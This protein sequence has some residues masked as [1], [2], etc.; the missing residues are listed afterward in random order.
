MKILLGTTKLNTILFFFSLS[1]YVCFCQNANLTT[2]SSTAFVGSNFTLTC[3][4]LSDVH[5]IGW[6]RNESS[7]GNIT[8][9]C[10]FVD[11]PVNKTLYSFSC[12]YPGTTV[13][14]IKNV[15]REEDGVTWYCSI[16]EPVNEKSNIITLRAEYPCIPSLGPTI[17]ING[18]IYIYANE[19]SYLII[20]CTCVGRSDPKVGTIWIDNKRVKTTEINKRIFEHKVFITDDLHNTDIGCEIEYE[21]SQRFNIEEALFVVKNPSKIPKLTVPETLRIEENERITCRTEA[22][23][24]QQEINIYVDGNIVESVS[25]VFEISETFITCSFPKQLNT[26]M[27]KKHMSCCV[28]GKHF[29][30]KICSPL[31][32][33]NLQFDPKN[34][35]MSMTN[36]QLMNQTANVSFTCESIGSNPACNISWNFTGERIIEN[37][38]VIK[39]ENNTFTTKGSLS[40]FVPLT[41]QEVTCRPICPRLSVTPVKYYVSFDCIAVQNQET[42]KHLVPFDKCASQQTQTTDNTKYC[43][44]STFIAVGLV[45]VFIFGYCL[46][47]CLKA[48][49][50]KKIKQFFWRKCKENKVKGRK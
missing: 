23:R 43:L 39:S 9:L 16:I 35:I 30:D 15:G 2:S 40:I 31:V 20:S 46:N 45:I 3:N 28:F 50:T 37:Q 8:Q 4:T 38:T 18:K 10:E 12:P 49:G 48:T 19:N 1:K 22:A 27:H 42:E 25:Q 29:P 32:V 17:Q 26:N 7:V 6:W 11:L 34:V 5:V 44:E 36:R 33:L 13:W 14:T 47:L 24:P 41:T 21:S